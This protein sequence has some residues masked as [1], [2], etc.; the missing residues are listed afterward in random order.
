MAWLQNKSGLKWLVNFR[1]PDDFTCKSGVLRSTIFRE[2]SHWK[3]LSLVCSSV[4]RP[5]EKK[6]R[7]DFRGARTLPGGRVVCDGPM[8]TQPMRF[9]AEISESERTN[10]VMATNLKVKWL[11]QA[12]ESGTWQTSRGSIPTWPKAEST[13]Q[14]WVWTLNGEFHYGW[15]ELLLSQVSILAILHSKHPTQSCK[16]EIWSSNLLTRAPRLL[17]WSLKLV[18]LCVRFVNPRIK[19][20]LMST[21][22]RFSVEDLSLLTGG[23]GLGML[24]FG[25]LNGCLRVV[26][27]R[28]QN[29]L[30]HEWQPQS[31]MFAPLP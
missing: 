21:S 30:P 23:L 3:W 11:N 28:R 12:T 15:R 1:F 2:I 6:K 8:C 27:P 16:L 4:T 10:R 7:M 22:L 13:W 18:A 25:L 26:R 9:W 29:R 14:T 17:L 19:P 24:G 20:M 5:T 31:L